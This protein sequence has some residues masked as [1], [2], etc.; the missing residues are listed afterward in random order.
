[1]RPQM[2]C[3]L[4]AAQGKLASDNY[5][6]ASNPDYQVQ[7]VGQIAFPD[8]DLSDLYRIDV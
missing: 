5:G 7:F 4:S 8:L 6:D 1:M 2:R 3:K